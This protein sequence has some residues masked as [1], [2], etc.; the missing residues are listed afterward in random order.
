MT[1]SPE[2]VNL[3][4]ELGA[5]PIVCD[6]YQAGKL[7]EV[8]ADFHPDI[9]VQQLTDLPD[10]VARLFQYSSRND[11]MRREGTK[12][13][14]RAAENSNVERFFVQSIAWELPGERG[15]AVREMEESVLK[16]NGVVLRYGQLYGPG[17][18]Y[19]TEK[20]AP[21]RIHVDEAARLTVD[22]LGVEP[23]QTVSIVE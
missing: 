6:V 3:L 22:A 8:M 20:P 12:H 9:V 13:M 7:Q 4:Q 10:D 17:T 14:L 19:P 11:R 16:A 23:G 1:R 18:F 15:A 2:N 5:V 21:P